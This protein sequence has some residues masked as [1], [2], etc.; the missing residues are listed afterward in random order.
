M[1]ERP[2]LMC[3]AMVR[4]TLDLTK[5]QTRRIV[6]PQP[7]F[8]GVESFGDSWK[9]KKAEDWFSGV[10]TEQMKSRAGLLHPARCPYQRG[11]GLWI[12]ETFRLS[13]YNDCAC[14]EPCSCK[15][16]V[17]IY[18][19][20]CGFDR[21]EESDPHWTPSIFMRREYSRI[22]LEITDVRVER[23]ADISEE[24]AKSEG[25]EPLDSDAHESRTQDH[26]D[27]GLCG[28]C[29]GLRLHDRFG[30]DFGI[31]PDT[32]CLECDTHA[33]RFRW[34][35]DSINGHPSPIRDADKKI[36]H[37][38]SFPFSGESRTEKFRGK[39]HIITA[40]PFIW[41]ISFRKI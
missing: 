5:W 11:N 39:P 32:D 37:Y 4:A 21:E 40:N 16:G 34:L 20:T 7:E 28:K 22:N 14:Y 29:G 17:P 3:G 36:T 35:W 33:K 26:F 10:T 13:D 27:K 15:A 30:P 2:I 41:A 1:K 18:R 12:K 24:D 9:W 25:V 8:E 19:A 31:I 23:V 6:K 38:V